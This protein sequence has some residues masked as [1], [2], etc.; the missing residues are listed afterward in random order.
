MDQGGDGWSAGQFLLN[1][2]HVGVM[3]TKDLSHRLWNDVQLSIDE[4]G[5]RPL[6][7]VLT[8]VL[9]SDHGPWSD[10]RWLQSAR[11]SVTTYLDTGT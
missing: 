10:A 5:L 3:V 2:A 6:C 7:T 8:I 4:A 9:N 1:A 11:E